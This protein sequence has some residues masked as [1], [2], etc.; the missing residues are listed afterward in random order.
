MSGLLKEV[1]N[2]ADNGG[3]DEIHLTLLLN[4]KN[5]YDPVLY[6]WS[7]WRIFYKEI[8][9]ISIEE[10]K[11]S[12]P[13]EVFEKTII[14][15]TPSNDKL[16]LENLIDRWEDIFGNEIFTTNPGIRREYLRLELRSELNCEE[17]ENQIKQFEVQKIKGSDGRGIVEGKEASW[18]YDGPTIKEVLL[19]LFFNRW[20]YGTIYGTFTTNTKIYFSIPASGTL[21]LRGSNEEVEVVYPI[22]SYNPDDGAAIASSGYIRY[23]PDKI[24]QLVLK[25]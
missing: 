20:K 8:F 24:I 14:I 1:F 2:R 6:Q 16:S 7:E 13:K 9:R 22:F 4:G 3:L 11:F 21:Y 18:K 19:L 17:Y 10:S 23:T 12:F 25:K 5:P 15:V